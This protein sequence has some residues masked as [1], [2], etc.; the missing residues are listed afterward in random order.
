MSA[1]QLVVYL[2]AM[3]TSGL[4][5]VLLAPVQRVIL[6]IA[7]NLNPRNCMNEGILSLSLPQQSIT[8]PGANA[9]FLQ[10]LT[11]QRHLD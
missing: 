8:I 3:P 6:L 7:C 11:S 4:L 5:R 2:F 10:V 1:D 9:I